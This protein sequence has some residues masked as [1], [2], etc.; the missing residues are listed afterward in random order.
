M[1]ASILDLTDAV[2][3]MVPTL[4]EC[5]SY[6][7]EADSKATLPWII[8]TVSL[9]GRETS[10]SLSAQAGHGFLETRIAAHTVDQVTLFADLAD[11]TGLTPHAEG[12]SIGALVPYADSG[13][14]LAPLTDDLT[15]KRVPIRVMRWRFTWSR[16]G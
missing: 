2:A 12:F 9:Q 7:D 5:S 14:Y 3:G 11:V 8:T 4:E 16:T 10:E 6:R 1:T 13:V 15:S